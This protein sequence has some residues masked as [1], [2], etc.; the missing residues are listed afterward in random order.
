ML[1]TVDEWQY[2]AVE[3]ENGITALLV[4]DPQADKAA[5]SM[6]VR[7]PHSHPDLKLEVDELS[8]L[9]YRRSLAGEKVFVE[10]ST[11][12]KHSHTA[13]CPVSVVTKA[14]YLS[15]YSNSLVYSLT[16]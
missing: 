16:H 2:R 15:C 9:R 11:S 4:S 6:D 3:L 14:D 8:I 13:A 7:I 12:F 10:S 5:A 1:P